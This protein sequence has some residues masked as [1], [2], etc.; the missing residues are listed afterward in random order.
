[1]ATPPQLTPEQRTNALAKAELG[2]RPA[3]RT[4]REGL[5]AILAAGG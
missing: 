4:Y 5:A 1:M 3:Y 2:W